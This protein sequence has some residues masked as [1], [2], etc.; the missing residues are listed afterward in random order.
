LLIPTTSWSCNGLT[1]VG[2]LPRPLSFADVRKS[3]EEMQRDRSRLVSDNAKS[4]LAM[5]ARQH[6]SGRYALSRKASI[7]ARQLVNRSN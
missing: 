1:A 6:R 2:L 4:I 7:E 3:L 5:I